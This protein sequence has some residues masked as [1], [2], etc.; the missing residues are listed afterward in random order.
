MLGW[1]SLRFFN[2]ETFNL[3]W[4]CNTNMQQHFLKKC[5][6]TMMFGLLLYSSQVI[7]M[8]HRLSINREEGVA[9]TCP[10]GIA[11]SSFF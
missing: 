3:G 8:N 1:V 2:S 4:E 11:F 7:E 5:V 10:Q 6:S 9:V